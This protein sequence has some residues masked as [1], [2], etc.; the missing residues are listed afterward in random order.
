M[1]TLC[2]LGPA[3]QGRATSWLGLDVLNACPGRWHRLRHGRDL[4][5]SGPGGTRA[6]RGA[7]AAVP[8]A[9][10]PRIHGELL[11]LA[12]PSPH[13]RLEIGPLSI[14][15]IQSW[16]HSLQITPILRRSISWSP[17]RHLLSGSS[18]HHDQI[19]PVSREPDDGVGAQQI[20]EAFLYLIRDRDAHTG[21][22]RSTVTAKGVEEVVT[23]GRGKIRA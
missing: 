4:D 23:T 9:G 21:T 18:A 2:S 19:V 16:R 12:F 7:G 8:P 1:S 14:A 17:R 15:A 5:R 22:F 20:Q 10:A 13:R 3:F 6:R 11:K